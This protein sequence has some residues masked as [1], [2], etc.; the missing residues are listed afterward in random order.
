LLLL[1]LVVVLST[2][3]QGLE[4]ARGALAREGAKVLKL[5]A[6]VSEL[7]HAL[8]AAQEDRKELETLRRQVGHP[9]RE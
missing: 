1:L 3:S 2:H 9:T 8:A 5:E 4:E 6:Q 7:Q